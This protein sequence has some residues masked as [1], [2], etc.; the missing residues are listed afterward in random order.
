M[1]RQQ[2]ALRHTYYDENSRGLTDGLRTA[3]RAVPA[4]SRYA[5]RGAK[6]RL[7]SYTLAGA[8]RRKSGDTVGELQSTIFQ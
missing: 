4:T 3:A 2:A 5:R 8:V 7:K 1:T 6:K